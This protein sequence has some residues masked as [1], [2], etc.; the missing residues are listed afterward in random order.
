MQRQILLDRSRH[1]VNQ[2]EMQV[3]TGEAGRQ[4]EIQLNSAGNPLSVHEVIH[5][6]GTFPPCSVLF[7]VCEDGLPLMLNLKDPTAGSL[8]IEG[9]PRQGKTQVLKTVLTSAACLNQADHVNFCIISPNP[10]EMADLNK[11]PHC[12]GLTAPYERQASEIILE[13]STI[14]EQRRYGRERG[15]AIILAIDDLSAL[16]GE[17]LDYEVLLHLRWLI[18]RGPGSEIWTLATIPNHATPTLDPEIYS[19][20]GTRISNGKRMRAIHEKERSNLPSP[21]F[22]RDRSNVFSTR[23]NSEIIQFMPLSTR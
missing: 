7:G 14:A 19:F 13:L 5:A 10:D 4:P 20:F 23:I 18:A 16:I 9:D 3:S 17:H 1:L 22:E 11:F 12:Q 15:P 8:L 21:F 6:F 2:F